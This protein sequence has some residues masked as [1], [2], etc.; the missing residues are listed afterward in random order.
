MGQQQLLLLVLATVVVG[1][2]TVAGI[3]AFDKGQ[4]QVSQD[5]RR[6]VAANILSDV[7]AHLNKPPELGGFE[8][9]G[10]KMAPQ[11]TVKLLKEMGYEAEVRDGDA[12]VP[13]EGSGGWCELSIGGTDADVYCWPASGNWSQRVHGMFNRY[14]N[15]EIIL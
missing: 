12:V 4:K 8:W 7:K 14:E 1:L 2:A 6:Q 3:K 9:P 13:I 10:P 11:A 15:G 5:A